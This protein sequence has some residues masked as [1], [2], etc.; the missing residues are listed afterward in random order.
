M[1]KSTAYVEGAKLATSS[2]TWIVILSILTFFVFILWL[3]SFPSNS[4]ET[5]DCTAN[6]SDTASDGS[7]S[8]D[9]S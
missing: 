4:G 1:D 7:G 9:T 6:G 5:T 8:G 2:K 3:F